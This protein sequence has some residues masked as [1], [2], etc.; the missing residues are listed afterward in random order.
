MG[1]DIHVCLEVKQTV[2]GKEKWVNVDSFTWDEYDQKLEHNDFY[3]GRDYDLF[4]ALAGVRK[5]G[6]NPCM[7]EK[8]MPDDAHSLTVAQ[9]EHW[10]GDG[11][12]HSWLTLKELMDFQAAHSGI[13]KRSGMISAAQNE[14]LKSGKTP[15]SWCQATNISGYVWAE[16]EDK[17]CPVD[18]FIEQMRA[19]LKS[20]FYEYE[21]ESLGQEKIRV[22]FWFDN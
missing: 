4:S 11:H 5:R 10:A 2:F 16:W 6:N 22:V 3:R 21:L 9:Y 19:Y 18:Y 20:R 8:G 14:E 7:K 15:D 13:V 1:C 17:S 12:S